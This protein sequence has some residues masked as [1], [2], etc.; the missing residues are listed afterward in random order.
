[1]PPPATLMTTACDPV[2][3]VVTVV[4]VVLLLLA[5]AT[6]MGNGGNEAVLV[7][8]LTLITMPETVPTELEVGVPD[9][10]P[11]AMLK[12]AQLGLFC[13]LKPSVEPLPPVAVGVKL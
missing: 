7:P 1:M 12:V 8:S 13:T 3:T 6:V 10:C 5:A 2:G 4:V 11:V 9:S